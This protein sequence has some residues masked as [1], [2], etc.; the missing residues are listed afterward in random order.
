MQ[1][2]TDILQEIKIK[3]P[4]KITDLSGSM[5]EIQIKKP[6]Y[7]IITEKGKIAREN[8]ISLSRSA[9]YFD[10]D[11]DYLFRYDSVIY[12][13]NLIIWADERILLG[14]K[15]NLEH[16]IQRYKQVMDNT[17]SDEEVIEEIKKTVEEGYILII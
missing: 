16:F 1:K 13:S 5:K 15:T 8:Y 3:R 2:L 11:D 7:I 14:D 6:R 9:D 10:I 17:L 4:V 12:A